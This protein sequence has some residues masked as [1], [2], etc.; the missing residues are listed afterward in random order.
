MTQGVHM[1]SRGRRAVEAGK[2]FQHKE[3]G[4]KIEK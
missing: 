1:I 3:Q 2:T 4:V